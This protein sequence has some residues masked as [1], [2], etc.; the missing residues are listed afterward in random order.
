MQGGRER[1]AEV[2]GGYRGTVDGYAYLLELLAG[3]EGKGLL[4]E[5]DVKISMPQLGLPRPIEQ[6]GPRWAPGHGIEHHAVVPGGDHHHTLGG[7]DH[8]AGA[9]THLPSAL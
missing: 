9:P 2:I 7:E 4:G 6:H 3:I 5:A 1:I 8:P